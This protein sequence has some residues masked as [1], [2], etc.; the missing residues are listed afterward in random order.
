MASSER[1]RLENQ[2]TISE[3]RTAKNQNRLS[4]EARQSGRKLQ[5]LKFALKKKIYKMSHYF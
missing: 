3:M 4:G 2:V 5:E 1:K